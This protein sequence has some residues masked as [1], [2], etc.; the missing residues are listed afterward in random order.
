MWSHPTRLALRPGGYR[1]DAAW[2]RQV[3]ETSADDPAGFDAVDVPTLLARSGADRVGVLKM[4]V[5]GAEAVV[6]AHDYRAWLGLVDALVIEL[7]EDTVFG[8]ATPVFDRAV[9]EYP[10]LRSTSGELTVLIRDHTNGG[11]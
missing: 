8:P 1:G 9:A 4:D 10:F 7:H 11:T 3:V 2:A 6:F 5:E